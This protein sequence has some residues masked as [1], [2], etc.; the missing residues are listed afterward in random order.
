MSKPLSF[1]CQKQ[2]R[3]IFAL[4]FAITQMPFDYRYYS[5]YNL[6]QHFPV[7][8]V[9]YTIY[10]RCS[11]IRRTVIMIIRRNG[12]FH[13]NFPLVRGG[14][15]LNETNTTR[16]G[17]VLCGTRVGAYVL[18]CVYL[19]VTAVIR[20]KNNVMNCVEIERPRI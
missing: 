13:S 14:I 8:R 15:E 6:L 5:F 7:T 17:R 2:D 4:F 10:I 12:I 20:W 9:S 16:S 18:I 1:I 11:N 19:T 3:L